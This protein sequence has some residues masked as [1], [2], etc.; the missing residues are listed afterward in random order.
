MTHFRDQ[1]WGADGDRNENEAV[2]TTVRRSLRDAN[3]APNCLLGL[4]P[5]WVS[6]MSIIAVIAHHEGW[7]DAV[8]R[9][10]VRGSS[11]KTYVT[12]ERRLVSL[13]VQVFPPKTPKPKISQIPLSVPIFHASLRTPSIFLSAQLTR[14]NYCFCCK[15]LL[16]P[17]TI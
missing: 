13:W 1:P 16:L 2:T 4:S 12:I 3:T 11:E 15:P 8:K 7:S 6:H 5:L 9:G 10:A 14:G 17:L